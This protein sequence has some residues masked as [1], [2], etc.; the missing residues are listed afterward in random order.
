MGSEPLYHGGAGLGRPRGSI[1][2]RGHGD[3]RSGD[4]R[5]VAEVAIGVLLR[6]PR[7]RHARRGGRGFVEPRPDQRGG[8][9]TGGWE[10]RPEFARFGSPVFGLGG[11]LTPLVR[12]LLIA[13]IAVF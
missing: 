2:T 12:I 5:G 6:A 8:P 4:E 9:M 1:H 13:N 11:P 3:G 7:R 10:G